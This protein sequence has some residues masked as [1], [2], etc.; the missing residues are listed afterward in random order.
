MAQRRRIDLGLWLFSYSCADS[1][2]PVTVGAPC[3]YVL[4]EL[5][6]PLERRFKALERLVKLHRNGLDLGFSLALLLDDVR[7]RAGHK[8]FVGELGV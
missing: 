6:L 1:K 5:A 7:G 3:P 2:F 8:F 4:G